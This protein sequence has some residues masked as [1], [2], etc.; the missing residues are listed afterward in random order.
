[1]GPLSMP[2][3]FLDPSLEPLTFPLLTDSVAI[4]D[5]TLLRWGWV[6]NEIPL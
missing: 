5:R 6:E 2:L 1:M 4:V 3:L